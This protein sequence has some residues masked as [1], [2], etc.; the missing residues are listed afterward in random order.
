MLWHY[1]LNGFFFFYWLWIV[2]ITV[3][4]SAWS[5]FSPLDTELNLEHVFVWFGK[6]LVRIQLKVI[7]LLNNIVADQW[8]F[9]VPWCSPPNNDQQSGRQLT[10]VL[11]RRDNDRKWKYQNTSSPVPFQ[12]KN[13]CLSSMFVLPLFMTWLDE[14]VWTVCTDCFFLHQWSINSCFPHVCHE[15]LLGLWIFSMSILQNAT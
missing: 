6:L 8:Y 1:W 9:S 4:S 5:A 12:N 10:T 15:A 14:C 3:W 2:Y 13:A 11:F 7:S